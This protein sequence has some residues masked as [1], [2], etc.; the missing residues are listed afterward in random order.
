MFLNDYIIKFN[1]VILILAD[2]AIGHP[3][4]CTFFGIFWRPF[5]TK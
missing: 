4:K 3:E 2:L 5:T 1:L